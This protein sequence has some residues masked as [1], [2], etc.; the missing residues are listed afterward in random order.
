M[1]DESEDYREAHIR[2]RW[3]V[4]MNN[5][6]QLGGHTLAYNVLATRYLA[7]QFNLSTDPRQIIAFLSTLHY[8]SY[9][10]ELIRAGLEGA[11]K[12]SNRACT[13]TEWEVAELCSQGTV[14]DGELAYDAFMGSLFRKTTEEARAI[15]QELQAEL[16]AVEQEAESDPNQLPQTGP[17]GGISKNGPLAL[18]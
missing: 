6:I 17:T 4:S 13:M 18:E 10:I 9:S 2:R 11:A 8:D 12:M 14:E 16:S 1:F 15:R 5:I 3:R 7:R